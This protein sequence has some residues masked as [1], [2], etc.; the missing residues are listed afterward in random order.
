MKFF[1]VHYV[2]NNLRLWEQHLDAHVDYLKRAATRGILRASGPLRERGHGGTREG[3]LIMACANREELMESLV[4]DPFHV[5][6]VIDR[7]T[8]TNWDPVF[9]IFAAESS[10]EV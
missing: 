1:V 9:G 6:G 5:H 10:G 8:I 3:M 7:M 2:H 4:T